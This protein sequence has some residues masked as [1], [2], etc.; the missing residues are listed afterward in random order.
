MT[1]KIYDKDPHILQ[2]NAIVL[3][4]EKTEDGSY[5][6]LL[7]RT[8]FFPEEGGQGS[9]KGTL[10]GFPV[11][12]VA[13]DNT[14]T[15]TH[16]LPSPLE[17]GS[18]VDGEVDWEQRFDYMQQHTG[19][20]ILSGLIHKHFGY[21]NVGFHLGAEITTLDFDGVLTTEEIRRMESL[22]NRAIY[23]NLPVKVNFPSKEELDTLEYRSKIELSGAVRIVEIPGIDVCAC[24][25]PH[26]DSIG[27]VGMLKIVSMEKHRGG[28]RIT[29]LCGSRA[30]KDYTEKQDISSELSAL[31]SA[32]PEV[33]ADA[34]K[35]LKSE[36]L[37]QRERMNALQEKLFSAKIEALPAPETTSHAILFEKSMDTKAVRNAVNRL[38]S[39]YPGYSAVFTG[40]EESGYSFIL[41][42]EKSDCNAVAKVLRERMQA[43][44]GGSTLMIQGSV[45]ATEKELRA[46]LLSL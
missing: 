43:K 31:L 28:V 36:N 7:D 25:A 35:R 24:C 17:T 14:D 41:G 15:L 46:L 40:S 20:H 45:H 5:A 10:N 16:F 34:V 4:C 12:H 29:I 18:T 6:V 23:E 8:A 42:S 2:F 37:E 21:N 1:E 19:E 30:L 9:D 11:L 39:I 26:V 32:K 22:A 3:S 13:I 38:S 33:L 27:Q 44:C